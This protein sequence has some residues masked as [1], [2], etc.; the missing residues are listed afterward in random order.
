MP[1]AQNHGA[2]RASTVASTPRCHP[3]YVCSTLSLGGTSLRA[4]VN[5]PA[6]VSRDI[7]TVQSMS[8]VLALATFTRAPAL[9][10]PSQLSSLAA[11]SRLRVSNAPAPICRSYCRRAGAGRECS[12]ACGA[13]EA[14]DARAA[15][16]GA[17][18]SCANG[19]PSVPAGSCSAAVALAARRERAARRSAAASISSALNAAGSFTGALNW[20][21]G[22]GFHAR[23]CASG[24]AS[25]AAFCASAL[26]ASR[27]L[28]V[29]APG[30]AGG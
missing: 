8:S 5:E 13:E 29:V 24:C 21:L 20:G 11:P 9:R 26:P 14:C 2:S 28:A 23:A 10:P 15:G 27:A 18:A 19:L 25:A 3:P 17:V 12:S 1:S 16:A 30:R 22:G 6:P 7:S 4:N